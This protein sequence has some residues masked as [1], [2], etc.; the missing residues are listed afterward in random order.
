MNISSDKW[1]LRWTSGVGYTL[2]DRKAEETRVITGNPNANTI[3]NMPQK[4]FEQ[5]CATAFSTGHWA[6]GKE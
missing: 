2:E 6:N 3:A 4:R 5:L 1:V